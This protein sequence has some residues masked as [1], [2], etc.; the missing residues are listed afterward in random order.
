M[1]VAP[2]ASPATVGPPPVLASP[3]P[4][5]AGPPS[6]AGSNRGPRPVADVMRDVLARY[7]LNSPPQPAP[8]AAPPPR[9]PRSPRRGS[10]RP[11]GV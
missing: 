4:Q 11:L 1:L 2:S 3:G 9:P 8:A 10:P 5:L 6:N 7:G